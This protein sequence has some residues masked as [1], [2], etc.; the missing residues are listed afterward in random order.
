MWDTSCEYDYQFDAGSPAKRAEIVAA[1]QHAYTTLL[2]APLPVVEL[3]DKTAKATMVT[4]PQTKEKERVLNPTA[5]TAAIAS[6]RATL[7]AASSKGSEEP[8]AAGGAGGGRG[9]DVIS[10]ATTV[11][12]AATAVSSASDAAGEDGSVA[13]AAAGGAGG[14]S[15]PPPP[16]RPANGVPAAPPRPESLGASAAAAVM[17][18]GAAAGGEEASGP[19]A[20]AVAA[21]TAV[22]ARLR[23][24]HAANA[25][26]DA[27]SKAMTS[28]PGT[29]AL[30]L[31]LTFG[32]AAL[33]SNCSELVLR[34]ASV[35]VGEARVFLTAA[36]EGAVFPN[37]AVVRAWTT[38][39]LWRLLQQYKTASMLVEDVRTA[40]GFD[41]YV[42]RGFSVAPAAAGVPRMLTP[43]VSRL[44]G[45]VYLALMEILLDNLSR[46]SDNPTAV[47]TFGKLLMRP[48]QLRLLFR[49]LPT[50]DWQV[51]HDV[52]KDMNVLLVKREENFSRILEQVDWMAWLPPLLVN[53][54][55][56]QGDRTELMNEYFKYVMNF[57]TMLLQYVFQS[58]GAAGGDVDKQLT[59]FI[60]QLR[61]QVGWGD[62]AVAVVRNVFASLAVKVAQNCKRWNRRFDRPEWENLFKLAAVVEDFIFY[63]PVASDANDMSE[64]LAEQASG[65]VPM[66]LY[67]PAN[68]LNPNSPVTVAP[69]VSD[70]I[71]RST[72]GLHLSLSTG[73]AEDLKLAQRVLAVFQEVGLTGDAATD[74]LV[75]SARDKKTKDLL[76]HADGLMKI[77]QEIAAFL[78]DCNKTQLL[79]N[80]ETG[81]GGGAAAAGK[82]MEK[83][84]EGLAKFLEKRQKA[85]K[86]GF[87][88]RSANKK[89]IVQALQTSVMK[90]RAQQTMRT[91]V[92]ASLA[93]KATVTT[94]E[95]DDGA[96]E[97]AGPRKGGTAKRLQGTKAAVDQ[98]AAA[99]APGAGAGAP[100]AT[101]SNAAMVAG[102]ALAS[103]PAAAAGG[104]GS[105][106][107]LSPTA[108]SP[109]AGTPAG[110]AASP[111]DA[112][113]K[114]AAAASEAVKQALT[115]ISLDAAEAPAPASSTSTGA[116]AGAAVPPPPPSA[117]PGGISVAPPP[118]AALDA[119]PAPS[120]EPEE[121]EEDETRVADLICT[122]C[123]QPLLNDD[124]V[125]AMDGQFHVNCFCC[126]TCDVPFRDQP[127]YERRGKAYC[128]ADY[129]KAFGRTVCAGCM[130]PL[131]KG[132]RVMAAG[133]RMYHP[134]HFC[135]EGCGE[136]FE[137]D[138]QYYERDGAPYCN[139]CNL[140]LFGTCAGCRETI[141]PD[142]P[143]VSALG[144]NWHMA[145][146]KCHEC[147]CGFTDGVFY[148]HEDDSGVLRAFCERDY[149]N[150]FAPRCR[151]CNE[152]V[153]DSGLH[154]CGSSWHSACFACSTCKVP[155]ADGAYYEVDGRP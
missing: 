36:T 78:E 137:E 123:S 111:G 143:A 75:T 64:L 98:V 96:E 71:D 24:L 155:F 42:L 7:R 117:G 103:S 25:S 14:R 10:V 121:G 8:P 47:E 90:Q 133:G 46:P 125:A 5:L 38:R 119:A 12:A 89:G 79:A 92:Q 95:L 61:L 11:S 91:T 23:E 52:M 43:P 27:L 108:S 54:P 113:G 99:A 67:M 154:A 122:R 22:V 100:S 120:S 31:A 110:S 19:A 88:S 129:L 105:A 142:R 115:S 77:F 45:P 136:H 97:E 139:R 118:P 93:A 153:K 1:L 82:G 134:E 18:A 30:D 144:R 109:L 151:A 74:P 135:C 13:S 128:R 152:P 146:I 145:C 59:R 140:T 126:A 62:A 138:A 26:N 149:L 35:A 48:E 107:P 60:A 2:G 6:R 85:Q 53:L 29:S 41:G 58:A 44:E 3:D 65:G 147:S 124:G 9:E 34:A 127:Y 73:E 33:S 80:V 76:V 72:P 148:T 56:K 81:G 15:P 141:S 20:A 70:P 87:L 150:L 55:R 86:T 4:K 51:K 104:A 112:S 32:E 131:L 84:L 16:T 130:D 40:G 132:Q 21:L 49:L 28:W 102:A 116:G 66:V 57:F 83:L 106:A 94:V 63:R 114:I 101:P 69:L 37:D 50:G 68:T 39:C 17:G